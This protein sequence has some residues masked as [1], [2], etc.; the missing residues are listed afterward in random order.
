M[1][2][3][4][5]GSR[6]LPVAEEIKPNPDFPNIPYPNPEENGALDLAM[7][8]AGLNNRDILIANDPDADRLAVAQRIPEL[9][10]P[11]A[12]IDQQSNNHIIRKSWYT[13][14]G[15][16]LGVLLA[17]HILENLPLPCPK[18]KGYYMLNSTVSSS[19]L[20]KMCADYGVHHRETLTGFKWMGSIAEDL[21]RQDDHQVPFAFEEALG[22]MFPQVCYDKDGV[23]A[24]S[25]FLLAA[26]QWHSRGMTPFDKLQQLYSK[27]GHH[28]TLNHYFRSP[29]PDTTASLFSQIRAGGWKKGSKF[30]DLSTTDKQ[31]T[32]SRWRDMTLGYDSDTSDNKPDLPIDQGSHMLTLWLDEDVKFT[33]RG[34]GTEPKVKC[35]PP[36][37]LSCCFL[38]QTKLIHL[39][40]TVYIESWNNDQQKAIETVCDVFKAIRSQWVAPFAPSMTHADKLF[41]SSSHTLEL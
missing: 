35:T 15:N 25:I 31:F 39:C 13:F 14:T 2:Q 5:V 32:I 38:V 30:G 12:H 24:A 33:L 27:Y 23:T 36:F 28:E 1:D 41:T 29:D 3:V 8:S 26:G 18:E 17:S 19:M 16:Q 22:Y 34:S 10:S 21:E 9:V 7:R 4:G 20:A 37:S 11:L 40:T 6:Y